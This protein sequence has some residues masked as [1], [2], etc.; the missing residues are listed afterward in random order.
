VG[1][2]TLSVVTSQQGIIKAAIPCGV[3]AKFSIANLLREI[4]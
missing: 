3:S 4:K 2:K 1:G